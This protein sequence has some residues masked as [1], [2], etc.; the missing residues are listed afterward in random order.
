M[1][2]YFEEAKPTWIFD[3]TAHALE[4]GCSILFAVVVGLSH[5]TMCI[6][7]FCSAGL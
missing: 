4:N 2:L 5:V 7:V 1:P 6:R 3:E